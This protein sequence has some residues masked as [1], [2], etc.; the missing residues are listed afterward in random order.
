MAVYAVGDIQGCYDDLRR[1]LDAVSFEPAADQLWCVG[2]LVNR[3]PDSLSV[4]RYIRQLGDSAVC[5][6]GNHDLHLLAVSEGNL[7]HFRNDTVDEILQAP[8]REQLLNWLRHLPLLHRDPELGFSLLHAGLPPQWGLGTA[9]AR[10]REVEAALQGPGFHDFCRQMYGDQPARWDD[11]LSGM[12][13]LRYI[14]NSGGAMP[15]AVL[16]AL[17]TALPK[18]KPYLMYGL[19]EA[20]RSTY[21]P[22]E[23]L[24]RRPDSMGR[25]IPN[26]EILVVREDGTPCLPGEPGELVHR[27]S[28]VAMG[29]WNDKERTAERFRPAPGQLR[30][31]PLSEIAVWSGDT[32]RKDEEGFLYFI[33]RKDD[34]IKTGGLNVYPSE[35]EGVLASHPSVEE[36]AVIGIS[37]PKWETAVAAIVRTKPEKNLTDEEYFQNSVRF[38]S[39]SDT[40]TDPLRIGA[41]LGYPAEGRSYGVQL[42]YRF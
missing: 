38:T 30:G 10:A 4:L 34:M 20:F 28:L 22:P 15:R 36:A 24:E 37:H 33:G 25:A 19:T 5:V 26:A 27:G 13:R 2:D 32:V 6:L 35:V 29:Y 12:Q 14:T 39:L 21:L 1:A 41:A 7:K 3:G 18:T 17:K 31:I 42:R 40:T 23:E 16:N 11:G 9:A 8:D